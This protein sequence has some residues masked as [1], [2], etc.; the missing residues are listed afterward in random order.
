M[1]SEL[2][3][4]D[5]D[6]LTAVLA[7]KAELLRRGKGGAVAV[8]DSHGETLMGLRQSSAALST[9]PIATNKAF[10][11]ARLKRPSVELGRSVRHPEA[12]FDIAYFSD[13]RYV[14]FGGGV[15]VLK[16]GVVVG[17]VG[18]SGLTQAEDDDLARMGVEA[19]LART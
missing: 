13:P 16:D 14:G 18:V 3:L 19:I 1:I 6:A 11:A 2:S 7:V 8:V 10:T 15:P 4:C 17:A 12:G 9:L 5:E